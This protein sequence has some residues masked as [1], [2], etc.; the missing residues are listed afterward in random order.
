MFR[1]KVRG[2]SLTLWKNFGRSHDVWETT[3][4]FPL[5]L[6]EDCLELIEHELHYLALKHHVDRHIG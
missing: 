1:S 6:R 2:G 5:P 4:R 3:R